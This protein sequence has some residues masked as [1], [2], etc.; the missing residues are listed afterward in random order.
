LIR[1]RKVLC[2]Y[3]IRKVTQTRSLFGEFG[4]IHCHSCIMITRRNNYN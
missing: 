1:K 2:R 3:N 4:S